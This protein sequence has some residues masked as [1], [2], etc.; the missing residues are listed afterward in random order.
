MS[1]TSS[2]MLL[3]LSL[4]LL[5]QQLQ[6]LSMCGTSVSGPLKMVR[7]LN[8]CGTCTLA[9]HATLDAPGASYA[10]RNDPGLPNSSTQLCA[11]FKAR[12]GMAA[13]ISATISSC[14]ACK[15]AIGSSLTIS[16]E[17]AAAVK[18]DVAVVVVG[19]V[20][21][22]GDNVGAASAYVAGA[23]TGGLP[24]FPKGGGL[25]SPAAARRPNKLLR[26]LPP[27]EWA[28]DDNDG[29]GTKKAPASEGPTTASTSS[30]R[31]NDDVNPTIPAA[32]V[33]LVV[34]DCPI[35]LTKVLLTYL[36]QRVRRHRIQRSYHRRAYAYLSRL[37][38]LSLG[39]SIL[40]SSRTIGI[41][42]PD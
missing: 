40:L 15:N 18:E 30:R 21:T 29:V 8:V 36:L 10:F 42:C 12:S 11:G 17:D 24:Q 19:V 28:Y 33:L 41:S 26:V 34:Y 16:S 4:L 13:C 39:V 32:A 2:S 3:L 22:T 31:S 27:L 1:T 35:V 20:A 25:P 9:N 23:A 6:R 37:L 5:S 14:D 7:L 38:N